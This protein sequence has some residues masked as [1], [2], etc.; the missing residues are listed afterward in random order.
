MTD[1]GS[2]DAPASPA[3]QL[4][5]VGMVYPNGFTAL[6]GLSFQLEVGGFLALTGPRGCGK[7]T[8]LQALAGLI[9]PTSGRITVGGDD[10]ASANHVACCFQDPR[11]LPWRTVLE[12]VCLPLQLAGVDRADGV[13]R[14]REALSRVGL[15]DAASRLPR[16]LSG[17][18][19][20]RTAIARALVVRPRLLLLD[21]PFGALDEVN[22]EQLDDELLRLWEEDRMTVVIVTH[23]LREAVY[24][25]QRVL[26]MDSGPGA[27]VADTEIAFGPR[28]DSTR[29]DHRFNDEVGRVQRIFRSERAS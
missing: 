8:V 6:S 14:S 12:N 3:L 5:E 13:Q 19:R 21:E 20:M 9:R 28:T 22:R 11:L 18:M 7:T 16:E 29:T 17:G 27:L 2:H 25:A 1:P 23:S 15:A 4:S 26:V 10:P 24:L